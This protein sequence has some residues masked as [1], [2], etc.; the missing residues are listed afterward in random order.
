MS[1]RGYTLI[2]LLAAMASFLS[3]CSSIFDTQ[4]SSGSYAEI[5]IVEM[6]PGQPAVTVNTIRRGRTG[7]EHGPFTGKF[8]VRPGEYRGIATCNRPMKEGEIGPGLIGTA[9]A[10]YFNIDF[11]IADGTFTLDCQYGK[12]G[13]EFVLTGDKLLWDEERGE[14]IPA[15]SPRTAPPP[16]DP[17]TALPPPDSGTAPEPFMY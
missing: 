7:V 14:P 5:E 11:P 13:Q 9:D 1:I 3:A 15:P 6:A 2:L 12:D 10:P 16:S 4:P 17:G 8:Y